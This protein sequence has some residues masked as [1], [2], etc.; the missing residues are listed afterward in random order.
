M[1]AQSSYDLL[2][3]E[4]ARLQTA[5]HSCEDKDENLEWRRSLLLRVL[6]NTSY[7]LPVMS[8]I[9][10]SLWRTKGRFV[11]FGEEN[12]F[13]KVIFDLVEDYEHVL[14]RTPWKIRSKELILLERIKPEKTL[15][16]YTFDRADFWI[17]FHGIPD[18]RLNMDYIYEV[19]AKVGIVYPIP[20]DKVH[21]LGTYAQAKVAVKVSEP[22]IRTVRAWESGKWT[23]MSH[24]S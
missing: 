4:I 17:Q 6:S 13:F 1:E 5:T 23:Y 12:K 15:N 19:A 9:L 21:E 18:N 11:L 10:T 24:H 8:K 3:E 20:K 2:C 7:S 16:Q 14:S 22:L